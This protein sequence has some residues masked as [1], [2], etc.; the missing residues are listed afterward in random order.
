M[1]E[2]E[3]ILGISNVIYKVIWKNMVVKIDNIK[4]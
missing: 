2:Y 1:L 3:I 4:T